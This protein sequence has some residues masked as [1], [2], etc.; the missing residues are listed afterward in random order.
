MSTS[1]QIMDDDR[2]EPWEA[3]ATPDA[4]YIADWRNDPDG[5]WHRALADKDAKLTAAETRLREADEIIGEL[6]DAAVHPNRYNDMQVCEG[7]K[8]TWPDWGNDA[9]ATTCPVTRARQWRKEIGT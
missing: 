2:R 9:H 4:A 3:P 6:V 5:V 7:C 8:Q 1:E